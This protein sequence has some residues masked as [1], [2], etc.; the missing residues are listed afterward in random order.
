MLSLPVWLSSNLYVPIFLLKCKMQISRKIRHLFMQNNGKP[1][2]PWKKVLV[3]VTPMHQECKWSCNMPHFTA[4]LCT[5]NEL[6]VHILHCK[7]DNVVDDRGSHTQHVWQLSQQICMKDLT[8][9]NTKFM[10]IVLFQILEW[11]WF[12]QGQHGSS[13]TPR[14]SWESKDWI[15]SICPGNFTYIL[16]PFHSHLI[17]KRPLSY[18]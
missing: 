18:K 8:S 13:E 17:I 6:H 4:R 11:C 12:V 3:K 9:S 10:W 2:R 15:I 1:T 7:E 5:V 16:I 14:S